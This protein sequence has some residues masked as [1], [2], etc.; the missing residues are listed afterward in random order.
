MDLLGCPIPGRQHDAAPH[1]MS[2]SHKVA[3]VTGGAKRIGRAIV[4]DLAAHGWAVVI[5]CNASRIDADALAS[6]IARN[7][8]RASVVEADLADLAA[9]AGVVYDSATTFGKPSL[10]VNNAS[11][12][13][14]DHVGSLE[15]G[16]F[17][18]QMT[19]NFAAPVFLAQAFAGIAESGSNIVNIVDQRAWR[20]APTYFSY[21][22]SKSALW[23]ATHTLAQALAPRIRVN[24]IAPG[25]VLKNTRQEQGDF[26]AQAVA[27]PLGRGPELAEFGRTIRYLVENGS[28]TGQ[29]IGLDGGQHLVWETPDMAEFDDKH[30]H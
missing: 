24:A 16:L 4:E 5:H 3:L 29:M 10:L 14:E 7:G 8:G 20:T 6:A 17:N 11:M 13:A 18:R 25:P 19:V 12:L 23:A 2:K 30:E 28:I 26:D 22:M 21:Q 9:V 27:L 1:S 15:P